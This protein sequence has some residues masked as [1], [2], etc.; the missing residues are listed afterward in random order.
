MDKLKILIVEDELIIAKDLKGI[1]NLY[2]HEAVGIASNSVKAHKLLEENEVNLVLLDINIEGDKNGIELA[3]EIKSK[4]RVPFIF[5]TSFSDDKTLQNAKKT[6]PYGYLLKPFEDE[7]VKVAIEMAMSAFNR[8]QEKS[9]EDFPEFLIKDTIFIK[10]KNLFKKIQFTDIFFI[11]ADSNYSVIH[12]LDRKYTLRSTLK[13]FE[14]KLPPKTFERV[15]KS[16]IVNLDKIEFI[17]SSF[18]LILD[19]ELPIS[20]EVQSKLIQRINKI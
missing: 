8:E 19:H 12:T 2:G 17:N 4:Y 1:V 11:K 18:V 3:D 14:G 7:D 9:Q 6:H 20:R 13:D 5:I 10:E 16:Y 15:H